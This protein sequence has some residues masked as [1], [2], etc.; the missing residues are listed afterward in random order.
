MSNVSVSRRMSFAAMLAA[1]GVSPASLVA[2]LPKHPKPVY[3]RRVHSGDTFN[4][5]RNKE[6]REARQRERL[7]R[8][9]QVA[10][11][12]SGLIVYAPKRHQS[13]LTLDML[14]NRRLRQR[15][16]AA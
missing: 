16:V 12:Q 1:I 8:R 5:G 13:R 9:E 4:A 10:V 15:G 14:A 11:F 6:K 2:S 7:M 3:G